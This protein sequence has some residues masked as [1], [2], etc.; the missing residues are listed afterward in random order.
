MKIGLI[1]TAMDEKKAGIGWYCYNLIKNLREID[2]R[3]EY[4]LIHRYKNDD[5]IYKDN[6]ELII[7]YPKIP[8]K[9]TIGDNVQIAFKLRKLK[10][11]IV[12]ELAHSAFFMFDSPSKKVITIH[13]LTPVLFPQTFDRFTVFIHKYLLPRALRKVDR[14]ITVSEN[15]KADIVKYFGISEEKIEV[16]HNGVDHEHFKKLDRECCYRKLKIK[17][18]IDSKFIL[19]VGTIEPRKNYTNLVKA[20]YELKKRKISHKLVIIGKT[21]WKYKSFYDAIEKLRLKKDVLLLGYVPYED[22][23]LFYNCA[24]VFVYPSL[25]EGF[26]LPPLEAMACG[27]PVVVSN[28][29]S[30][31]EVVGD[32]GI[33]VDP[34][35]HKKLAESLY[36]VLSDEG[37]RKHLTL[38]GLRR[39]KKFSWKETAKKTLK[40]YEGLRS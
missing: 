7:P 28:C 8:M 33:L 16:I 13:D 38:K 21:G 24:E 1:T 12:H 10:F 5:P 20:F 25:Y 31:P 23:P 9:K 6:K 19:S 18:G 3:N 39:A 11:D 17:Y 32:A 22:L 40:V 15:T 2:K 35:D 30:L 27:C 14:I 36:E 26:G 29:S 37:L 4:I 34:Y